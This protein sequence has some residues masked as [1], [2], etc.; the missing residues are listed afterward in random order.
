MKSYE[1]M[2][3]FKPDLSKDALDKLVKQVQEI[4]AKHKGAIS[5]AKELGKQRLAYAIQKHKEG[6]YYLINF[7]IAPDAID[8]IKK[9]LV[10]N[11]S[12]LRMLVVEV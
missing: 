5:Q 6:I 3:I 11:E 9:S 4:F 7:S 2:F 1:G 10:L 8:G 12:V